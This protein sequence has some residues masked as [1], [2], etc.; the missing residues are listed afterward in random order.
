VVSGSLV[1]A[2][3]GNVALPNGQGV[4]AYVNLNDGVNT[5]LDAFASDDD[6]RLVGLAQ[7]LYQGE[8]AYTSDDT[9]PRVIHLPMVYWDD[10]T[11]FLGAFL[12][13]LEE[14]GE[15]QLTFDNA[16]YILA[17]CKGMAGR[18]LRRKFPP[19][20]WNIVLEFIAKSGYFQDAAATTA[21]PWNPITVDA[22]QNANIT[23]AG[24]V[25]C[26][27]VW[28]LD[29]PVGNA[30]AINSFQLRNTMSG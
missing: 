4:M 24:S 27:P 23:Y 8:A 6:N 3:Y 11:H 9:G 20:P 1:V 18:A 15:Q 26:K 2:K 16:T 17:K 29:V 13:Q 5:F 30:V 19:Y 22:G 14:A 7:L 25:W 28:V 21:T 10:A 12:A